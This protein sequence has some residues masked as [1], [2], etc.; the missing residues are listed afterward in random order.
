MLINKMIFNVEE[1]SY[2]LGMHNQ[3][4]YK[5]IHSGH[6][7]AYKDLGNRRWKITGESIE[8]YRE[9]MLALYQNKLI[10]NTP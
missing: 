6:L 8:R 10:D 4:I 2:I 9:D 3:G 5:L 1:A 7:E